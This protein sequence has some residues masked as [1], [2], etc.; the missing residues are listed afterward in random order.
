[1]QRL[2]P[3]LASTLLHAACAGEP[4]Q[5]A[6]QQAAPVFEEGS[7]APSAESAAA[8][9]GAEPGPESGSVGRVDAGSAPVSASLESGLPLCPGVK[10]PTCPKGKPA[11]A[12]ADLFRQP[13]GRAL[14]VRGQVVRGDTRCTQSV[15]GTC[16]TFLRLGGDPGDPVPPKVGTVEL[17]G[18]AGGVDTSCGHCCSL[19]L[20][21]KY[22]FSAHHT[23]RPGWNGSPE[24]HV[25]AI[26]AVCK[27]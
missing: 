20:G 27:E 16:V 6:D 12:F 1:M 2:L 3:V 9:P 23:T 13:G 26:T 17:E 22:V 8:S 21:S 4:R 19:Q 11:L 24:T 15:P 14:D 10:I 18:S 7:S 25:L 5:V